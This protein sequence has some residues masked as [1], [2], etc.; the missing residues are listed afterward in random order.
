M[1]IYLRE[2]TR[3]TGMLGKYE[4]SPF[5]WWLMIVKTR[6]QRKSRC[7]VAAKSERYIPVQRRGF[8]TDLMPHKILQYI[9]GTVN[10]AA[11]STFCKS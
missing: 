6:S 9:N 5:A 7:I 2:C 10:L 8:R 11:A 4:I 3:S 1:M